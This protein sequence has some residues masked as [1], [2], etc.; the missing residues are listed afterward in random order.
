MPTFITESR[1]EQWN[2]KG[3]FKKE[4]IAKSSKNQ[5]K[6]FY[7]FSIMHLIQLKRK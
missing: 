3:F 5:I 2:T 6:S 1:P 7:S 4:H